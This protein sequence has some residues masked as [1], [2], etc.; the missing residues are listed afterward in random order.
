MPFVA[1]EDLKARLDAI[2][3]GAVVRPNADPHAAAVTARL[4]S[5][6]LL[7]PEIAE[8]L[9]MPRERVKELRAL[10]RAI[11]DAMTAL[12]G[13]YLD[14]GKP[15][16][17]EVVQRGYALRAQMLERLEQGLPHEKEVIAWLE[18][19][20]LGQGVV[21]LVY[22]L[23]TLADLHREHEAPLSSKGAAAA[24]GG[25]QA[26]LDRAVASARSA[27][28]SI[29]YALRAGERPEHA[30]LRMTIARAWTLFAPGYDAAARAGRALEGGHER[31]FPPLGLIASY[32]RGRRRAVSLV[33]V[34]PPPPPSNAEPA[35]FVKV[36][37]VGDDQPP[38]PSAK[39][40]VLAAPFTGERKSGGPDS[41]RQ[42]RHVIEI[43]IGFASETN[44]YV[45]FT[46]NL[47]VSGV[48]IATYAAK[49]IGAKIEVVLTLPGGT[50]EL[51]MKGV[52]RWQRA[53]STDGWPGMGVQFADVPPDAEAQIRKFLSMREPLFY[54]V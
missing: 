1:A 53:A 31:K 34:A 44:F 37:E 13:E 48:F 23:R 46:E 22:D 32:R 29:E 36:I 6:W 21:D 35:R 52:V 54:D 33:P 2:E 39:S 24:Q 12:G 42:P 25:A 20:K 5:D 16:P 49:P 45:G 7:Q 41:R 18:A 3:D 26:N 10:A 47:S 15:V 14:D 27:A 50:S 30:K 8:K 19:I 17:G 43:E 9:S 51:R 38:V 40:G 4:V 11:L 28:D